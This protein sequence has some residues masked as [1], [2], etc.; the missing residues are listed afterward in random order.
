MM[1]FLM[2]IARTVIPD[3]I[4]KLNNNLACNPGIEFPKKIIVPLNDKPIEL[5]IFHRKRTF[6]SV[7]SHHAELI[8]DAMQ[9]KV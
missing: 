7:L 8:S 9:A 1:W 2:S 6:Y 4:S 5:D 3:E